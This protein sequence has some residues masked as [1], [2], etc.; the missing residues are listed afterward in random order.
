VPWSV[1]TTSGVSDR[2]AYTGFH[3]EGREALNVTFAGYYGFWIWSWVLVG[4]YLI[5]VPRR[6]ASALGKDVKLTHGYT[7]GWVWFL[8]MLYP[9]CWGLSEGGNVISPDSEF[10]FYG[11]LDCN[12]ITLTGALFLASHWRIDP[13]RL[14]LRMR[15]YDDPITGYMAGAVN[16]GEKASESSAPNPTNGAAAPEDATASPTAAV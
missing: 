3:C 6:F 16:P 12:L 2:S 5:W 9:V 4:Y 14:G 1:A 7:A 15:T 8:W 13:A 11:I 10:I